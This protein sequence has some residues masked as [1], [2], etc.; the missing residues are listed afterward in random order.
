MDNT[1]V[2]KTT[3]EGDLKEILKCKIHILMV[4]E[5]NNELCKANNG[6]IERLNSVIENSET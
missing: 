4:K 5:K 3:I 1:D 2:F 6:E